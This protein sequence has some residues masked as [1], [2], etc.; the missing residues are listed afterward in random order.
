MAC[1][2]P[3]AFHMSFINAITSISHLQAFTLVWDRIHKHY[4][5]HLRAKIHQLRSE[6]KNTKKEN[7]SI[8]KYVVR[9]H[10]LSDTLL[11]IGEHISDQ[12]KIYIMLHGLPKEY[13][14]FVIM[15]Y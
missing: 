10:T 5:S 3:I 2:G 14:G 12:D 7:C 11:A 6:L 15:I 9:I 4:C 13:N 8:S 1:L